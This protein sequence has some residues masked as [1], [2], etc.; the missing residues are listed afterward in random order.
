[1]IK[2]NELENEFWLGYKRIKANQ[3]PPLYKEEKRPTKRLAISIKR[4]K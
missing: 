3:D 1:M 4:K 2:F